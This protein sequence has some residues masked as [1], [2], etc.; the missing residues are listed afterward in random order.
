MLIAMHPEKP[1]VLNPSWAQRIMQTLCHTV[2]IKSYTRCNLHTVQINPYTVQAVIY[3]QCRRCE[4]LTYYKA[5]FKTI[6]K[7]R[8]ALWILHKL[9]KFPH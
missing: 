5:L 1:C 7:P 2:Q 4:R 8:H 9:N 6:L 3:T